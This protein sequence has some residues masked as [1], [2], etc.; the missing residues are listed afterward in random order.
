LPLP[1]TTRGDTN[2]LCDVGKLADHYDSEYWK[3]Q[4]PI[5]EIGGELN[6]W[7][8]EPY[9]RPTDVVLDFGCG[10]GFLINRLRC[11]QRIGVE[12]STVARAHAASLGLT[13]Y[14]STAGV[15]DETADV[16]ISNHAL[17]HVEHPLEELRAL[18]RV[19][20]PGG[21]LVLVVPIDDW[22]SQR[23]PLQEDPNHHLYTWTPLLLANL[24][25]DAGFRV[26]S[27]RLATHAWSMNFRPLKRRVPP[28]L[29]QLVTWVFAVVKR[30]RQVIAVATVDRR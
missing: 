3:Y 22:R 15:P 13:V 26:L 19:L 10:G 27:S 24:L 21:R 25:T 5:G 9:V 7:K 16:V 20:K 4:R 18:R 2:R 12:P 8:F 17:E 23:A 6:L 14:A 28:K 11:R 1:L 30:R 29:Y